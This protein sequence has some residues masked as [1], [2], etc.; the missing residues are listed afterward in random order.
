MRYPKLLAYR[1]KK[2]IANICAGLRKLLSGQKKA[3][4]RSN[5]RWGYSAKHARF[6][7]ATVAELMG[8]GS[9]KIKRLAFL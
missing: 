5:R 9:V 7:R 6:F 3:A 1:L 4:E 2:E 8:Q